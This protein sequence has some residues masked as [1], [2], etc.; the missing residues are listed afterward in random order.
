MGRHD[1]INNSSSSSDDEE[2]RSKDIRKKTS[3]R[4]KT[5]RK[6]RKDHE[7]RKEHKEHKERKE[8]RERRHRDEDGDGFHRDRK[9]KKKSKRRDSSSDDRR[10]HNKK[11]RENEP[12]KEDERQYQFA[13][14]LY[15]LFVDYPALSTELPIMFLRLASG[16]S[17][18]LSNMS[19]IGAA[20]GLERV[21]QTM[22]D[23]GVV[24]DLRVW[25]WKAP[26]SSNCNNNE[27][28]LVRIARSL[29]DQV[30]VTLDA[31][32]QFGIKKEEIA[33][34]TGPVVKGPSRPHTA[35]QQDALSLLENFGVKQSDATSSLAN[36]LHSICQM[37]IDGECIA[38]DGMP[39]KALS[40]ALEIVFIKAG[41]VKSEICDDGAEDGNKKEEEPTMGYGLPES[42]EEKA[43]SNLLAGIQVCQGT[44]R[45]RRP[46]VTE[47]DEDDEGPAPVGLERAPASLPKVAQVQHKEDGRD[48]WMLHPG[49]HDFLQGM[50]LGKTRTFL[51]KKA[52]GEITPLEIMDPQI[53]AQ[54]EAIYAA[55][56]EARG[57]SLMDQH[58]VKVTEERAAKAAD[59]KE[60]FGWNRDKDLDAGRRVDKE[61]L[62]M[63]LGGASNELKDK[64]QGGYGRT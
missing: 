30:G 56:N 19:D 61:A 52:R 9:T 18:D 64:F 31:V 44:T 2:R 25:I 5:K 21:F 55:H 27:L 24:K 47:I 10:K 39:D 13:D 7:E 20:L 62:K 50:D 1:E 33:P 23:F 34:D 12:I 38:I 14:A 43:R 17:L 11:C 35:L 58:R 32:N 49:E 36:E 15:D 54:V 46:A 37:I 3:Q 8:Q 45:D 48:E 63:I 59:G 53:Q 6:G 60:G 40:T 51:N 41:L 16:M 22:K 29:L 28:L 57:P 4:D 26:P 42:E